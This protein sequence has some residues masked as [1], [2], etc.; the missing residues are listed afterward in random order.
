MNASQ[1]KTGLLF[2]SFN[3]VHIGHLII[4]E[5][6][7]S[8]AALDEIW[9][10]VSPQN[11]LK[12]IDTLAIAEQRLEMVKLAV[13]KDLRFRV[14]EIEF[15]MPTPSYTIHTLMLLSQKYARRDFT[16]II[17]TDGLADFHRWKDYRLILEKYNLLVYP[18]FPVKKTL[19]DDHPSVMH[20]SAPNIEI[21]SSY[22]RQHLKE[23]KDVRYMM[24]EAVYQYILEKKLY[25]C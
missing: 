10:V 5:F 7:L 23:K 21:S 3:P 2:G 13:A 14:C 11:P 18:R 22:I 9:F 4:A 1:T 20:I 6:I 19:Y 12:E 24:P 8:H 25:G 17:G 15:S 16:L